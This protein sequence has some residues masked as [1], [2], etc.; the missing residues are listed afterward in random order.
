MENDPDE[1]ENLWEAP[2]AQ[3]LKHELL[4][5]SFDASIVITDPGGSRIGR[6]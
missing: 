6:Y 5:R 3:M 4:K 1:F 2:A